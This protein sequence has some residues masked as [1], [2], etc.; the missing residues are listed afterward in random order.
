[1]VTGIVVCV[2][3]TVG[4]AVGGVPVTVGGGV[5]GTL[6]A[7]GG[8]DAVNVG[9]GRVGVAEFGIGG[10]IGV[11]M[12]PT[13]SLSGQSPSSTQAKASA[14]PPR[15]NMPVERQS[16]PGQW[17]LVVH[18]KLLNSPP[19]QS[20]CVLVQGDP[21]KQLSEVTSQQM[22]SKTPLTQRPRPPSDGQTG[23][24]A[25]SEPAQRQGKL[26]DSPPTQTPWGITQTPLP[27]Q[28][29]SP[30]HSWPSR[31]P[32]EHKNWAEAGVATPAARPRNR[33]TT[34]ADLRITVATID[35][36]VRKAFS[37]FGRD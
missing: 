30:S 11:E 22:P 10:V 37:L 21:S 14:S 34:N 36:V 27:G 7:V 4:A 17:A 25:H 15:Q 31:V 2:R 1:M 5:V 12:A 24:A 26:S 32:A 33:V 9:V 6:V 23:S 28:S 8:G 29:S 19:M 13:H 16:E 35:V 3:V 20:F 18:G